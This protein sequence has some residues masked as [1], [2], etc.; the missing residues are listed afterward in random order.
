MR[1]K[2]QRRHDLAL[3]DFTTAV[4][5]NGTVFANSYPDRHEIGSILQAMVQRPLGCRLTGGRVVPLLY[6]G[7]NEFPSKSG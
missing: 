3:A 4:D 6:N 2:G 5:V 7:M 1:R